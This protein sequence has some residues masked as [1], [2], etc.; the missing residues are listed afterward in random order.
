MAERSQWLKAPLAQRQWSSARRKLAA[1][2]GALTLLALTGIVWNEPSSLARRVVVAAEGDES[3]ARLTQD[4][5]HLASDELEGRGIGTNGLQKAAEF[6]A[7]EFK[8]VG[9]KTDLF[10]GEPYQKFQMLASVERGPVENN[11]ITF[12][13][14]PEKEGGE[15]RRITLQLEKD[16]HTLALGGSGKV[17]APVV[18]AGYGIT[19]KNEKYDDY[20][21]LD[22]AGKV[23]IIVRREPQQND[24]KSVFNGTNPSQ[25]APFFRKIAN[26][27]EHSAAAVIIVNDDFTSNQQRTGEAK[28]WM[29]TAN[30]LADLQAEFRKLEQPS[31]EDQT[32]HREEVMKQVE[33]LQASGDRLKGDFDTIPGFLEAGQGSNAKN[34][35]VFFCR[36]AAIDPILKSLG[37]DLATLEKQIDDGPKPQS[38]VLDGWK[39]DVQAE[40]LFKQADV[41]NV[42]GVLEGEGPLADETIVI[43]AH[44][45]H[46][47]KG[48]PGSGSLSNAPWTPDIHNGADDNA[49]GTVSLLEVARRLAKAEKKPRRRF[50]FIAFTGEE[51]GL[52]GSARYV[53]EPRFPLE[54]TVAMLNMDMVGRLLDNKL[55][56]YGTGTATEFDPLIEELNKKHQ[57]LLTKHPE[58]MGPS[59]HASFYSKKIPV[60][61]FFTGT[62]SDYH[63]PSDDAERINV[64]GMRRIVDL[65]T[66]TALRIAETEKRP[67]YLEVKGSAQIERSG[68]RPYFGSIPDFAQEGGGYALM[69]VT[70]GS[71]AERGGLK[72]GDIIIKM[73]ESKIGSLEDFDSALRKFKTGDKVPVTVKRGKETVTLDVRLDAPR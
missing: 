45:D 27:N 5:R 23:V 14:P 61:H 67:N 72:A 36:R 37:T 65:V 18:F 66:E 31:L 40:V 64:P 11:S 47:G 55:I 12:T 29:E 53:R 62:H 32:K 50:V 21:G 13:G 41:A 48:G 8:K 56:V 54:N 49:S 15:P 30:K 71:P 16:F 57:F 7:A 25:H 51:R 63:R 4:I 19:G 24:P 3:E 35:P 42:V 17:S 10:A 69:G 20:E 73:G 58:G 28:T 39:A 26:A 43:G 22:V 34:P 1:L 38:R 46:L 60:F 6:I 44:Y 9:L 59:D 52:I 33:R 68:D 70:K 2:G